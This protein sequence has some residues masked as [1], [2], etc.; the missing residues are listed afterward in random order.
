MRIARVP[1]AQRALAK[2]LEDEEPHP[3]EKKIDFERRVLKRVKASLRLTARR[4][5]PNFEKRG[6]F[7]DAIASAF[8]QKVK[9]HRAIIILIIMRS[10]SAPLLTHIGQKMK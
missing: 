5:K 1:E 10:R 8:N 4:W 2:T 9:F 6:W 3:T 7:R